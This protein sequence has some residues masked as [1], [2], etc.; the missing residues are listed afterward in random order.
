[1]N[2][3][4]KTKKSIIENEKFITLMKLAREEPDVRKRIKG[5]CSLDGF[6]RRSL[7]NTWL[8]ELRLRGAPKDF[9]EALSFF[10]DDAV[11]KKALELILESE[12]Q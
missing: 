1:M 9:R 5:L 7:L 3:A 2:D 8:D 11:A 6:N 12:G 10:L 4:E